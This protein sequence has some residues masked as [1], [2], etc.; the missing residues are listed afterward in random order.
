M[1]GWLKSRTAAPSFNVAGLE[2]S[3]D[4]LVTDINRMSE[5]KRA[6]VAVGVAFAFQT[7]E[8][9]YPGDV[10]SFVAQSP[11]VQE[12]F[13]NMLSA[14]AND[15][16]RNPVA[17]RIHGQGLGPELAIGIRLANMYFGGLPPL[18]YEEW[19]TDA[20][21][22]MVDRLCNQL[23]PYVKQGLALLEETKL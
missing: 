21:F 3:F 7:F 8:Q 16:Q 23:I 4:N 12:D 10:Q 20:V 13:I 5:D 17:V 2:R 9:L 1:F 6:G 22:A 15:A 11:K 18:S 14:S 19:R